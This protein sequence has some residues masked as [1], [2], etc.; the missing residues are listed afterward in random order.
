MFLM[1]LIT[2]SKEPILSLE[3]VKFILWME[4]TL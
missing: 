1:R 2:K 3:M 4:E